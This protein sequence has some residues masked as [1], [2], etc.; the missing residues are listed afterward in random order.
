VRKIDEEK[1]RIGR[2]IDRQEAQEDPKTGNQRRKERCCHRKIGSEKQ[3]WRI[4]GI[5]TTDQV[6]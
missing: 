3:Q 5:F 6:G 2:M 4:C 1:N